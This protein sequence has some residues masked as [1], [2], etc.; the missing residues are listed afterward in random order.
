[1]A[2]LHAHPLIEQL[3][4]QS[5]PRATA[6]LER[7]ERRAETSVALALFA[8]IGVLAL[9]TRAPA[10]SALQV[11]LT[12]VAYI[13]ARRVRFSVGR[14]TA[15]PTEPVLV[16]ML[17]VL[18]PWSVPLA[19]IAASLLDR[20]PGYLT[21]R[22]NPDRAPLTIADAW[23]AVGPAV[24]LAA[25]GAPEPRLGLWPLY[26]AALAAQVAADLLTSVVREYL[27]A[28]VP[29]QLQARLL[30]FVVAI[31][32][33]LA[34]VGLLAGLVAVN[35]PWAVL[36]VLPLVGL[37]A[38]L[39]RERE[40][41]IEHTLQLSEAYRGTAM[42]MGELLSADDAYTGGE[43][44]HG[45]VALACGV[46]ERMGLDATERRDLEFGALLH[47]IGKLR[48]PDAIINKPGRLTAEEWEIVKRHP[49]DGQEM[50][51]RIG[52]VLAGVGTIVRHHHERWDGGGYPDGL[53]GTDIPLAAR[54]I[55]ACDAFSAMTTNRSY[56][57]ALPL[58]AAIAELRS[59]A[60][61]QFDPAVVDAL[62]EVVEGDAPVLGAA[63]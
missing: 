29:P 61:T 4:R 59:C 33:A 19:V 27:A 54:I 62:C 24:V 1:M 42:L 16:V 63:A 56:R 5:A 2:D 13:A 48:V 30:G 26:L 58:A 43:H 40:R 12:I 21:G 9:L 55:C 17:L 11:C 20:L 38:L 8:A 28:G 39:G 25:A 23:H 57:K 14:G 15:S 49:V 51:E 37:L 6:P 18:P 46:G 35:D 32:A 36:L 31:D 10:P 47:D 60:G 3:L 41:R 7:R 50:L 52:G 22:V 45:V 53:V 34:P 44:T